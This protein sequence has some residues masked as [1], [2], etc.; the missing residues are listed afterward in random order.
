MYLKYKAYRCYNGFQ[1][2]LVRDMSYLIL[3]MYKIERH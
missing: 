1:Y 3:K 2:R